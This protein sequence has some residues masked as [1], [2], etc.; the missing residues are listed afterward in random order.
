[1][2]TLLNIIIFE[3]S[4]SSFSCGILLWRNQTLQNTVAELILH[5]LN[6]RMRNRFV[7]IRKNI[8]N[9]LGLKSKP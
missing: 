1:M 8:I 5:R 4:H 7:V 9:I 6:V 2:K 3:A